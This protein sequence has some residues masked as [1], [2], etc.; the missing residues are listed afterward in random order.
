MGS[1]IHES[2]GDEFLVMTNAHV[3]S[4][5]R[6][7]RPAFTPERAYINSETMLGGADRRRVAR[8]VWT[9]PPS[10]LDVTLLQLDQPITC[11]E[12]YPLG[13][14]ISGDD[15]HRIYI[16]GHPFGKGLSLSLHDN[17][18]ID[19]NDTF[20][21]Y[22][23]PTQPGSSGSPVF[24][25]DWNLIGLHHSGSEYMPKLKDE[26][27]TYEANEGIGIR[28]IIEAIMEDPSTPNLQ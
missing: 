15:R 22:R 16:I 9:S 24:D 8:V 25:K 7:D 1:E 21:H 13:E 4:P 18:L 23:T 26:Y 10:V 5:H 14:R 28:A 6:A 20:I 19:S 17:L 12:P 11:V 2:L 27:E 3:V